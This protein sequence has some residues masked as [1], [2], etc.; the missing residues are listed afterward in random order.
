DTTDPHLFAIG[1][2]IQVATPFTV[3]WGT[4]TLNWHIH[5]NRKADIRMVRGPLTYAAVRASGVKCPAL[6]GDPAAFVRELFPRQPSEIRDW[7][8]IPHYRETPLPDLGDVTVLS[9]LLSPE[10]FCRRL[11]EHRF[12]LSSSLHGLI[13]A[14][15]Y[16]LRAAWIKLSSRPLGDD[17]KFRD[18]LLS[19]HLSPEPIQLAE[20]NERTIHSCQSRLCEADFNLDAMRQPFPFELANSP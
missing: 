15:S 18:Y 5:V 19:Q 3:V 8:L 16:G 13:A 4:G 20:L 6:W 11:C 1:S 9:P 17:T 12:A 10:V 2:M 7:C 14:H